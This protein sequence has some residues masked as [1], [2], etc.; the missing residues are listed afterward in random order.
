MSL[1]DEA[2]AAAA[3][4]PPADLAEA[5]EA[6]LIDLWSDLS[7]ALAS[8]ANGEWSMHCDWIV[9]RIVVLSRITRP[10]PWAKCPADVLLNGM[11]SGIMATAGLDV[12]QPD[13]VLVQRLITET[14]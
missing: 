13:L 1:W 10:T 2:V 9:T 5:V 8:A 11:Y 12:E 14:T 6:E 7:S 4:E 3:V